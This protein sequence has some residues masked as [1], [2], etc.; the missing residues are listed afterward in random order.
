MA[1][2]RFD[3]REDFFVTA[4]AGV[5][6]ATEALGTPDVSFAQAPTIVD[7]VPVEVSLHQKFN[8]FFYRLTA[9]ATR[10]WF[11]DFSTITATGLPGISRDRTDYAETVRLGYEIYDGT[12][13]FIAP[14][15]QQSV[16]QQGHPTS[17]VSSATPRVGYSRS[18]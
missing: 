2:G 7:S 8:R 17:P 5:V 11:Y 4:K 6:R 1:D 12:S 13:V 9:S 14:G 15:L 10:Y 16:Y 18:A 3:I